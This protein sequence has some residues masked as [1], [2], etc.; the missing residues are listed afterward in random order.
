M[1]LLVL[2]LVTGVGCA[3][4][5]P[6]APPTRATPAATAAASPTPDAT[7]PPARPAFAPD[8]TALDN[9]AFFREV[10]AEVWAGP[11]RAAGRS[12]VDALV[13]G[14]FD[15]AAMQVTSDTTTLG[16]PAES[17]Q[18]SVLFAG[19]CLIGQV[20]PETGEPVAVVLPAIEDGRCLVGA[21]RPIDW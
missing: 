13:A 4:T 11:D 8:G 18:F 21:T 2:L 15:R 5:P 7:A 16:N 6:P 1:P 19:E 14:G 3:A 20:G 10:V 9:L 12:Y 17:I